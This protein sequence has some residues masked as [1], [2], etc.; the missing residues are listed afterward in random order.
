ME[1]EHPQE[2]LWFHH[3]RANEGSRW[4]ELYRCYARDES[5]LFSAQAD[6]LGKPMPVFI[7]DLNVAK[8][9]NRKNY[10]VN[11]R[12]DFQCLETDNLIGSYSRIGRVYD[13]SDRKIG[14]W[15][16]ARKWTEEFKENLIDALAN[17][18]FGGGDAP[19]GANPGDVQILSD[20][21]AVLAVL[22]REQMPFFPD[23]PKSM[24]PSKVA[25]LASRVIPGKLGKS[26]GEV[27]PP[28]GWKL[29]VFQ[30]LESME[31]LRYVAL[32]HLEFMRWS[33]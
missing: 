21:K 29:S 27:T 22:Q 23:P 16:D 2:E 26:L 14:R 4:F 9:M 12:T 31:L 7:G 5:V 24:E 6:R 1:N 17:A 18:V 30:F 20:G 11:G 15:C 25:K 32:T 19:V 33:R 8:I 3:C 10:V 13:S 28:S